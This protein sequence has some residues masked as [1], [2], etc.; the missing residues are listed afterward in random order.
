MTRQCGGNAAWFQCDV[1]DRDGLQ[2]AV[3][4]AVERF[5]GIDVVVANAGI[6]PVGMTRSIDPSAFERTIEINLLG[7]WRTVR[8]CLPH[9]IE[10]RGYVLVI[11]SLAAAMHGPGMAAYSASK[12]G[13]E[14]F[15]DSLRVEVKQL[16][17]DVGV[18]YFSFID[19]EMVRAADTHPAMGT[20]APEAAVAVR[21]YLPGVGRRRG[22]R[23]GHRRATPLGGRAGLVARPADPADSARPSDR[24][25]V[26]RR[27]GR[28]RSALPSR[29]GG[30]RGGGRV[31]AGGPG[32]RGG[33]RLS[34]AVSSASM[35]PGFRARRRRCSG[36]SRRRGR[37]LRVRRSA[38]YA[39]S[40]Q[41]TRARR[42]AGWSAVGTGPRR[43][44]GRRKA[45]SSVLSVTLT[46]P[47]STRRSV[48]APRRRRAAGR[49]PPRP[50]CGVVWWR[51]PASWQAR[52]SS[53]S[54]RTAA[55]ST[56]VSATLVTGTPR[57]C[58]L[59][60]PS[61]GP[62][63][64]DASALWRRSLRAAAPL[65]CAGRAGARRPGR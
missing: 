56:R 1:T 61:A 3:D 39:A 8:A 30:A 26:R 49:A 44:A 18:G 11:A 47:R 24:P 28:G 12:A 38:G 10:R 60:L 57:Q 6:A 33:A 50:A 52:A 31:R 14:A 35:A 45:R 62:H 36:G 15:A 20:P 25:G 46:S 2:D 16:G 54:F 41:S 13:A 23:P 9:V 65:L 34:S 53:C 42:R 51:T 40:G 48:V 64:L 4:G 7:V 21:Q 19:T 37:G 22:D 5:G 27:R 32:R 55:R 59:A 43:A 63:P 29:R 17:V 58:G